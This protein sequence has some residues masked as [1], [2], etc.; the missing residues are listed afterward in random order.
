MRYLYSNNL[1]SWAFGKKAP[2]NFGLERETIAERQG[3]S[4]NKNSG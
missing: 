4:E 2:P 3:S 1:K